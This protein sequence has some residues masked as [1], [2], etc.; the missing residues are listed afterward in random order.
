MDDVVP[1]QRSLPKY[2]WGRRLSDE[3]LGHGLKIGLV[4]GFRGGGGGS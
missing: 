3:F 4:P 2:S 1:N